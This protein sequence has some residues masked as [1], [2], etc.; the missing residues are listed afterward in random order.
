MSKLDLIEFRNKYC[1][2]NPTYNLIKKLS[3]FEASVAIF[4]LI[5]IPT[6]LIVGAKEGATLSWVFAIFT[7]FFCKRLEKNFKKLGKIIQKIKEFEEI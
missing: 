3:P 5:G 1:L 6:T 2:E 7:Y 4:F